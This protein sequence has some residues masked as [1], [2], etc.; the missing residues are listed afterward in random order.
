[1]NEW[2]INP[3]IING[4][5][6]KKHTSVHAQQR[7]RDEFVGLVMLAPSAKQVAGAQW[8]R[9]M[10]RELGWWKNHRK[11]I[12]NPMGILIES[13]IEYWKYQSNPMGILIDT[14]MENPI[15]NP[16]ENSI[17]NP[18]TCRFDHDWLVVWNMF[19]LPICWEYSSHLTTVIFLRG[20]G[21]PPT[22][23]KREEMKHRKILSC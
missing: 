16:I 4:L 12:E 6:T 10:F 20:V 17:E 14:S 2:L 1:M 11:S 23:W 8:H 3:N 9:A 21:I 13:L 19:H 22:R 15:E 7:D 5:S 18:W